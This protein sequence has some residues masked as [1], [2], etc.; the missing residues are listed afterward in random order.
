MRTVSS[1]EAGGDVEAGGNLHVMRRMLGLAR[2]MAGTIALAVLFGIVGHLCATFIP[3]LAVAAGLSAAGVIAHPFGLTLT[4]VIAVLVA[5]SIVRGVLHYIE[6]TCNH[7]IA[8]KLLAS[9]RDRVFASLRRLAPA[10]LAGADKGSLISTITADVE[11]LEVFYAHTI[12]PICIAVGTSIVMIVFMGSLHPLFGLV[13][14]IAYLVVG[15][16]VP[17]LLSRLTGDTGRR[18]RELAGDLSGFV[19]DS[20]RGLR[21]ARQFGAGGR[22]LEELDS[23]SRELVRVQGLLNDRSSDGI[24]IT[25]GLI[26]LFGLGQL[27]LG[28]LLFQAGSVGAGAVVLA[29]VSILSSFGPT[30][31]LAALGVTLQGTIASGAR[32]LAVLDEEPVVPEQDGGCDVEFSG[33]AAEHVS[34]SYGGEQ[35]LSDVSAEVPANAIV[36]I[37]GRSGSGKSTLCRLLMR[38]WDVDEGRVALSGKDVRDINTSSLR[39]AEALVEQDTHLFHDSILD[40]LLLA[41]PDATREQVEEACKAASVHDFIMS[42]PQGYDTMVGELGDTLSG[43]ERQRLGLAR[44][45]LHG[46][47]F[48]LLDEP[49]SNLDSLNEGAILRSLG[50]QRASRTVL[51]ISHRASTMGIADEVIEMRS[52][53]VS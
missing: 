21:E 11:L 49:T 48:L 43:G 9:I 29:T 16:L 35:I 25:S 26:L 5:M 37:T 7:Y 18:C 13:G 2:P 40:N 8:F 1:G 38:F 10:K 20:L 52:G 12:S 39:E 36:G 41:R 19:L 17:V 3:V 23:R 14:L 45:F 34:F 30:T 6:Q 24:A 4:S 47:P 22:R 27:V 44:A 46:A 31:A 42:L 33:A 51:L 53:R 50:E 15:A 32:V 28:A